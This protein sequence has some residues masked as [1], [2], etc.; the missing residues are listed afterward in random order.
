MEKRDRQTSDEAS[1]NDNA[2]KSN[3]MIG[4]CHE[5]LGEAPFIPRAPVGVDCGAVF[6]Q[7][8]AWHQRW[9]IFQGVFTPGRNPVSDLLNGVG[10]PQDLRGRKVLDVG[11]FNCCF[12]FECER[13]GAAEVVAMDLQD[14]RDLGF[15]ALSKLLGSRVRFEQ[16]SVYNLNQASLGEFDVVLFFGVLYH[17]RYPLL[18][19]D[20]LRKVTKGTLFLETLVIDNRFIEGGRDFQAIANYHP[21]LTRVA[22]WQFYKG[23]ELANDHSNWFGP[24]IC[25]VLQGLESAGFAPRLHSSWGDRA[26]F[27]ADATGSGTVGPSYEGL[28]SVVRKGLNL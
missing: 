17:L 10:L 18:A 11:A 9:E 13:R 7:I 22:L 16:G 3:E 21:A 28:S 1:S 23:A 6:Q 26:G 8:P 14:P 20:Q 27:Q 24:N 15:I 19:L 5:E 25:A 12:S 2:E 4:T